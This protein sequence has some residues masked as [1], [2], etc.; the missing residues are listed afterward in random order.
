MISMFGEKNIAH[1]ASLCVKFYPCTVYRM[2]EEEAE[3]TYL[4]V[5]AEKCLGNRI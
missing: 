1:L 2:E 4:H 3:F 5:W